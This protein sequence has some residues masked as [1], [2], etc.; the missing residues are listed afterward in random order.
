MKRHT[1]TTTVRRGLWRLLMLSGG[2]IRLT[3]SI[4][5]PPTLGEMTRFKPS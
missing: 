3:Q 1:E 5:G 2:L 4:T